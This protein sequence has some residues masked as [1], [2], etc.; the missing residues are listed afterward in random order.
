MAWD[1]AAAKTAAADD[2]AAQREGKGKK[3]KKGNEMQI[4]NAM[5]VG[6]D[7]RMSV[8]FPVEDM[9]GDVLSELD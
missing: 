8:A 1:L 6:L 2:A 5:Q 9:E 3:K 4:E 7:K